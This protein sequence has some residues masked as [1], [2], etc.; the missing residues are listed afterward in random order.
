MEPNKLI[1]QHVAEHKNKEVEFHDLPPAE[2]VEPRFDELREN[3]DESKEIKVDILSDESDFQ[4][5][6][7][8]LAYLKSDKSWDDVGVP[9]KLIK[10]LEIAGFINPSQIQNTTLP[11]SLKRNPPVT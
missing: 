6:E 8:Y 1:N 4:I 5:N 9:E 3:K 2:E 10:N 7:S 11:F